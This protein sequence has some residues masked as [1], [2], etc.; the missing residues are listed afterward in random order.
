MTASINT[1]TN[2]SGTVDVTLPSISSNG[3]YV[4]TR[5]ELCKDEFAVAAMQALM[6]LPRADLEVEYATYTLQVPTGIEPLSRTEWIAD[7]SFKQAQ[8]MLNRRWK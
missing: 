1:S 4:T 6:S 5:Q 2:I 3:A 8:A 7:A